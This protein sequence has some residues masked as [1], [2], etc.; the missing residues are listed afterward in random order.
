ME[1]YE[2]PIKPK[3][4]S[5]KRRANLQQ[6]ARRDFGESY[7]DRIWQYYYDKKCEIKLSD[8]ELQ[9]VDRWE[10]AWQM[11]RGMNT[12]TQIARMM[13]KKFNISKYTAL[14]DINKAHN[15]YGGDPEIANKEAHREIASE[16]A[17]MGMQ[18]AWKKGDLEMH[19]RYLLRYA[20]LHDL[21]N[22]DDNGLAALVKKLEPIVINISTDP[23][24]LQ[25]RIEE[26]RKEIEQ[27]HDI[28]YEEVTE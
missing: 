26:M 16:W 7:F 4:S 12:K 25:K 6:P 27:A 8:F 2:S 5:G 10:F 3:K 23:E 21:E 15:L 17:I 18:R 24:V 20:K 28:D 22:H 14:D 9:L 1:E 19:Q 13:E 11:R